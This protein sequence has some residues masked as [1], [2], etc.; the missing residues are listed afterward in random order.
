MAE[1]DTAPAA[2]TAPTTSCNCSSLSDIPGMTGSRLPMGEFFKKARHLI[3]TLQGLKFSNDD[4]V[5]LQAPRRATTTY[6]W[7]RRWARR[8]PAEQIWK[9]TKAC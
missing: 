6:G 4:L 7:D 1:I 9:V 3:P 8:W 5:E 2:A